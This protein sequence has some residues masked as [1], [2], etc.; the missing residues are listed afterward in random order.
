MFQGSNDNRSCKTRQMAI[1][2][3]MGS[4]YLL[5]LNKHSFKLTAPNTGVLP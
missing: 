2:N 5:S 3:L 4:T 1:S